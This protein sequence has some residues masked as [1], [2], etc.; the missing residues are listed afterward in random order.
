MSKVS[1]FTKGA[2][3]GA[4]VGAAM[5]FAMNPIDGHDVKRMQ[6]RTNRFFSSVGSIIDNVVD[7][8]KH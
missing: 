3:T 6:R 8:V 5:A 1:T 2:V 7:N 4:V